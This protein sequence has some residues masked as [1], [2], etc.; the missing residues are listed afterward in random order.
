MFSS[1][2]PPTQSN[3]N[4][5][6]F[7]EQ[8]ARQRRIVALHEKPK[9]KEVLNTT[10]TSD[11]TF[12]KKHVVKKVRDRKAPIANN[13]S[14]AE[15][16]KRNTT[17][18][19]SLQ[20]RR[21]VAPIYPMTYVFENPKKIIAHDNINVKEV[22]ESADNIVEPQLVEPSYLLG[23]VVLPLPPNANVASIP[24]SAIPEGYLKV[25]KW[26]GEWVI[27]PEYRM[28]KRVMKAV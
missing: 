26:N 5:H 11:K 17:L 16:V 2:A 4:I 14:V 12:V 3:R 19:A 23:K 9:I 28:K 22:M 27:I 13:V 8:K 1:K 20:R 6:A 15:N 21:A 18:R 25:Q 7:V 10:I 24:T